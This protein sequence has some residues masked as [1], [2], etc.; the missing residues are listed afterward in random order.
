MP[1]CFVPEV[2]QVAHDHPGTTHF[3]N[4]HTG[5]ARLRSLLEGHH[6]DTDIEALEHRDR[7]Q[8][9]REHDYTVNRVRVDGFEGSPDILPFK[10]GQCD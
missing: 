7:V 5:R 10:T 2:Q 3:V 8:Q 6:R 4:G 1:H 9:G